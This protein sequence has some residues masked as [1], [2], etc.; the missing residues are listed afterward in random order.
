[1]KM[2]GILYTGEP[3][4]IN[5]LYQRYCDRLE[6][7]IDVSIIGSNN[8]YLGRITEVKMNPENTILYATID[9]NL[10]KNKYKEWKHV[11]SNLKDENFIRRFP[12]QEVK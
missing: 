11:E 12:I 9:L 10:E 2:T 1:M 3:N 7:D 8:T 6:Q 4:I 5:N